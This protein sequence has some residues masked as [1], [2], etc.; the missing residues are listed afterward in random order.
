M[1]GIRQVEPFGEPM[2]VCYLP[3]AFGM[4]SQTPQIMAGF[5]IDDVVI[6]RGIP[7][8]TKT[9]FRWKG[10]D[11]TEATAFYMLDG[12]GTARMLPVGGE[13]YVEWVE[14]TRIPR[15]GLNARVDALVKRL[16]ETQH[17]PTSPVHERHRPCFPAVRTAAGD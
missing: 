9:V 4:C 10:A 11:G 1:Y 6:W 13:D 5:D 8:N 7:R 2:R 14:D 17:Q 3:D 12:Y 16:G 15:P